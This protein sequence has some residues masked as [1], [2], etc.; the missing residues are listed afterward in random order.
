MCRGWDG[1]FPGERGEDTRSFICVI[2]LCGSQDPAGYSP[3]S[4]ETQLVIFSH[5]IHYTSESSTKLYDPEQ[6]TVLF[7]VVP[8]NFKGDIK[9]YASNS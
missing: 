3:L 7:Q 4:E 5:D 6:H 8:K 2:C 9:E 1:R